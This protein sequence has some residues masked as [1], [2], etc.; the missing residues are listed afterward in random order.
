M[1]PDKDARSRH[2]VKSLLEHLFQ[3]GGDNMNKS[4][5][6]W[7]CVMIAI[8]AQVAFVWYLAAYRNR[9][10]L[11]AAELSTRLSQEFDEIANR[12]AL[13]L[14]SLERIAHPPVRLRMN[15]NQQSVGEA[16]RYEV[17]LL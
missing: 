4:R 6:V 5:L 16:T 11:A 10:K 3:R 1:V 7:I 2:T 12:D 13:D 14:G 8:A 15:Y 17:I 9:N